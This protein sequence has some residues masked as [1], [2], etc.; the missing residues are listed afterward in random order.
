M[1]LGVFINQ[2]FVSV[3]GIL[4]RDLVQRVDGDF[5]GLPDPYIKLLSDL[6]TKTSVSGFLQCTRAES[7]D[8]LK[9]EL[10]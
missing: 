1:N 3:N 2:N 8:I 6:C 9:V 10:L 5:G 7:L 4:V